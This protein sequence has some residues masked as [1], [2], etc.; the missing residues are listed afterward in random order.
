M[1]T[2]WAHLPNAQHIDWVLADLKARPAVW[3]ATWAASRAATRNAARHA[4][5]DA[6]RNAARNAAWNAARNAAWD[7]AWNAAR[8]AA[9]NVIGALIAYDDC[10]PL[11]NCSLEH[12]QR[13]YRLNP[14]PSFLLLQPAV[15]AKNTP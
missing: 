5:W 1:T 13:L 10:A 9:W 15:I 12:L 8:N 3:G 14:H 6:A 2:A 7:A 11:L 4:A